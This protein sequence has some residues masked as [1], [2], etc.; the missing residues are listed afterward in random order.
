MIKMIDKNYKKEW[1]KRAELMHL[2]NAKY[3]ESYDKKLKLEKIFD[4]SPTT[5]RFDRLQKLEQKIKIA[6]NIF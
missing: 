2:S 3:W 5:K 4:K 1:E 6:W